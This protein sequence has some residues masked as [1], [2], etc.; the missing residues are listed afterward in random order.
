MEIKLERIF[1]PIIIFTIALFFCGLEL[2]YSFNHS[3]A[4]QNTINDYNEASKLKINNNCNAIFN[5]FKTIQPVVDNLLPNI[6]KEVAKINPKHKNIYHSSYDNYGDD[7]SFYNNYKYNY[8][9]YS[10]TQNLHKLNQNYSTIHNSNF[11]NFIRTE[12]RKMFA[13]K[14]EIPT[15][16]SN[17]QCIYKLILLDNS[18][19]IVS[20]AFIFD[21]KGKV[22]G[23]TA[24]IILLNEFMKVNDFILRDEKINSF[25]YENANNKILYYN[26]EEFNVNIINL[27]T[28]REKFK[29]HTKATIFNDTLSKKS[30]IYSA[31][32][33]KPLDFTIFSY[34]NY[35][36]PTIKHSEH[37]KLIIIYIFISLIVIILIRFFVKRANKNVNNIF[38]MLNL[39]GNTEIWKNEYEFNKIIHNSLNKNKNTI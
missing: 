24:V 34:I 3:N 5:A 17:G 15:T 38:S 9:L 28:N 11:N 2:F 18:I 7:V 39:L 16:L 8:I 31:Q 36:P 1:Y 22:I 19:N 35:E 32:H 6:H 21:K 25:L 12:Y 23:S 33:Y 26:G 14:K 29:T 10:N 37:T 27:I 4:N 20:F 13:R 30:V